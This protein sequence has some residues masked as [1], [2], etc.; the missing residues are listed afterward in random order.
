MT[1]T[2]VDQI[3]QVIE[4]IGQ[5]FGIAIDWTAQNLVPVAEHLAGRIINWQIATSI[6][7][8]ILCGVIVV[9][10]I[11]CVVFSI[12]NDIDYDEGL[13]LFIGGILVSLCFG[14]GLC[15]NIYNLIQCY[16]FPELAIFEY[17]QSFMSNGG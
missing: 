8:M 9:A 15:V 13:V 12:N 4:Y 6:F 1:T 3:I 16:C 5:K 10:G 14:I 11:I 2:V 7:W 17:I